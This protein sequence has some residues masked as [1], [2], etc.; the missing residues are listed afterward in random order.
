MYKVNQR[1]GAQAMER[2]G[3]FLASACCTVRSRREFEEA[4]KNKDDM[5]K[6]CVNG[7]GWSYTC[8]ETTM[9]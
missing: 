4:S 1:I 6:I 7:K 3:W 2:S 9:L 5:V 8:T